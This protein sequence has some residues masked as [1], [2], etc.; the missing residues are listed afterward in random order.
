MDA[1]IKLIEALTKII[2]Q[3]SAGRVVL[4]ILLAFGGVVMSFVYE[5]RQQ[6]IPNLFNSPLMMISTAVGAVLFILGWL[7]NMLLQRAEKKNAE[8]QDALRS[9]IAELNSSLGDYRERENE[10]IN[11]ISEC[12]LKSK[13]EDPG[14]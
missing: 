1:L 13:H 3:L 5:N 2:T 8:L 9:R 7:F 6:I 4:L 14:L 10:L 11:K 12:G